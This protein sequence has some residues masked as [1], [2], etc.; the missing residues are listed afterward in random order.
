MLLLQDDDAAVIARLYNMMIFNDG[1]MDGSGAA[2]SVWDAF[3]QWS[4][5]RRSD[6]GSQEKVHVE[7]EIV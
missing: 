1:T 4:S 2:G 6:I 7:I 5:R 3:I